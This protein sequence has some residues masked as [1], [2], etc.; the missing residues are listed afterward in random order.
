MFDQSYPNIFFYEKLQKYFKHKTIID[1]PSELGITPLHCAFI[2][3]S[4]KA[5]DLLIDLGAN[6]NTLDKEGNNCLH[7]TVNSNN[8]NL[9]IKLKIRGADKS[10][11]NQKGETPL[12][13][14]MQNNY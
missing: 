6:I 7:Y 11:R 1:I 2:K 10:V 9:L 12:D 5:V 8:P 14:A 3:G 13:L 4:K